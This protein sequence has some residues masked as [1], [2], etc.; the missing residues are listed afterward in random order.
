MKK[1]LFALI[2]GIA[3]P[4]FGQYAVKTVE[5]RVQSILAAPADGQHVLLRGEIV[6]KIDDE[7]YL[8]TDGTGTIQLDIDDKIRWGQVLAHGARV[9]VEGK[10]NKHF[11]G[12]GIDIDVDRV[13]VL[14]G[15]AGG[16]TKPAN[17]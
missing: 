6:N 2:M 3:V 10:V 12:N 4:V 9:E 11:F 15:I 13:L 16:G 8:F 14:K 1:I 7:E 17:G 5:A